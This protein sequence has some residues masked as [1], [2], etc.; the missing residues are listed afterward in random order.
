MVSGSISGYHDE[1]MKY[2]LQNFGVCIK[3]II[4]IHSIFIG[5]WLEVGN[6]FQPRPH[7]WIHRVGLYAQTAGGSGA[8]HPSMEGR[9]DQGWWQH[10]DSGW[11]LVWR[12]SSGLAQAIWWVEHR[13]ADDSFGGVNF[14]LYNVNYW[15]YPMNMKENSTWSFII[16]VINE[17]YIRKYYVYFIV[18]SASIA[19]IW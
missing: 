1:G 17:G 14:Y 4:P 8:A 10:P 15:R 5:S 13:K 18:A 12:H 9:K 16:A 19:R 6:C 2:A 7:P 11:C 3:A